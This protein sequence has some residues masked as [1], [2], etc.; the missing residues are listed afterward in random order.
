MQVEKSFEIKAYSK[1]QMAEFY[2]VSRSTFIS[3]ISNIPGLVIGKHAKIL[4]PKQVK[5]IVDFLGFP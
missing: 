4:T 2:G 5:L 1:Q 3:W